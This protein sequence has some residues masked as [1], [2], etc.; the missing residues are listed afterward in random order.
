M[1][2]TLRLTENRTSLP[3]HPGR[4]NILF[5]LFD[6][7]GLAAWSPFGGS[8]Q[9]PYLQKLADHGLM[10]SQWHTTALCSP[11]RAM[12]LT[13]RNH[14]LNGNASITEAATGFPGQHARIPD[15]CATVG[16]ILQDC[17]WSTFWVG[18]NHNVPETGR[19]PSA[20]ARSNGRWRRVSTAS[21]ASSAEKP[22]SS[23]PI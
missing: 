18:K 16:Q 3:K 13:G 2:V 5:V 10:Y 23:I 6:D 8:I 19:L 22:T 4:T 11:T 15:Q 1:S 12:L 9:M 21:T 20:R 14:H 7:T 17:G